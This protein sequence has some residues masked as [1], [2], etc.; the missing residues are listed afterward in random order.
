MC[1][2]NPI[3]EPDLAEYIVNAVQQPAM[4]NKALD[5]GGPDEGLT[6]KAQAELLFKVSEPASRPQTAIY[7][8][9]YQVW[10]FAKRGS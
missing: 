2:C 6:P 4:R 10:P 8:G 5:V 3:S 9:R 7:R 1:R